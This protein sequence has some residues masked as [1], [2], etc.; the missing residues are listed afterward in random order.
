[1]NL[2]LL[3][4]MEDAIKRTNRTIAELESTLNLH[5]PTSAFTRYERPV[6]IPQGKE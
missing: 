3:Q 6:P 5:T 1:M 4:E 2:A